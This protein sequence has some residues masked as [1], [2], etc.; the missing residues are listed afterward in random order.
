MAKFK[1]T[2]KR[3]YLS[4][5]NISDIKP[6]ICMKCFKNYRLN[7]DDGF[8]FSFDNISESSSF[9]STCL[10]HC[11]TNNLNELNIAGNHIRYIF[12]WDLI[13]YLRM[14]LKLVVI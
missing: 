4:H 11:Y 8:Y 3:L 7:R 1:K 13:E 9:F 12:K 14:K 5:N 2:L 6:I 10:D